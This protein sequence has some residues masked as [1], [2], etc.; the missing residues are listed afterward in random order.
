MLHFDLHANQK[1][2]DTLLYNLFVAYF[3]APRLKRNTINQLQ[4]E[5]NYETQLIELYHQ[6]LNPNYQINPNIA[7]EV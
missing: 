6:I 2:N 1:E 5:I 7:L 4:F 3:D